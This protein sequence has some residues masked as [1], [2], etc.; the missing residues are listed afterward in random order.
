M[1]AVNSRFFLQIEE[2]IAKNPLSKPE[3]KVEQTSA[4]LLYAAMLPSL[5]QVRISQD[6]KCI[7]RSL[8]TKDS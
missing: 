4:E 2:E 5:P 3:G 1:S 6:M 7:F 8:R